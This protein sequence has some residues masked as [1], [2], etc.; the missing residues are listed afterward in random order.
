MLLYIDD[1]LCCKS[2]VSG[3]GPTC[4]NRPV[5]LVSPFMNF[6][7]T[8]KTTDIIMFNSR[9]LGALIVDE[10]A[11]V[12]EWDEPQFGIQNIGIEE[13]Y[14]FGVLNEGQAIAVARC[15]SRP[16]EREADAGRRTVFSVGSD[17]AVFEAPQ[18]LTGASPINV[19]AERFDASQDSV[20]LAAR[21]CRVP[22]L[23]PCRTRS[24][25]RKLPLDAGF[26]RLRPRSLSWPPG[27]K[28]ASLRIAS[29]ESLH[30][31]RYGCVD[32]RSA[33][34]VSLGYREA[35]DD[36]LEEHF[37]VWR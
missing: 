17:D 3:S 31:V 37:L 16:W 14:G 29:S 1:I 23:L 7:T 4:H 25:A 10:R 13:S 33:A 35:L 8:S 18:V 32:H 19:G 30:V 21:G 12:R 15:R 36:V 24:R 11:H 2:Q 20:R 6:D 28:P 22:R 34:G 27:A 9:N 26:P 5:F